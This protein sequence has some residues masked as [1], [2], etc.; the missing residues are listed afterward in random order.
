ADDN[1]LNMFA[2]LAKFLPALP[3]IGGGKTRFQP[4]YVG[5]VAAA[6]EA[7]LNAD[8]T[9]GRIYELGGPATYSF[10]ELL[11]YTLQQTGTPRALVPL[12]FALAKIQA[13]FLSLLP[14]PLLTPDQVELLKTDNVVSAQ[15]NTLADL[16]LQPQALE[17]LAP[18]W[19]RRFRPGG[20]ISARSFS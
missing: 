17:V 19:L 16:G 2:G 8:K 7:C 11:H 1:F 18:T 3:L 10:K 15:A 5:D 12:P 20:M 14:T 9:C 13:F 4:I 6:A